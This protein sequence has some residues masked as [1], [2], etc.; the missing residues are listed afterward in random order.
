MI[1]SNMCIRLKSGREFLF[2]CETYEITKN[3]ITGEITAYNLT[4]VKG[5][6]PLYIRT[7]DIES[8]SRFIDEAECD[9]IEKEA[10]DED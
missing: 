1:R 3:N 8:I 5:E 2:S 6:C 4:N 10:A 9:E 7:S